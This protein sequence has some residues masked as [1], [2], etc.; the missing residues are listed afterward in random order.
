MPTRSAR[1]RVGMTTETTRSW[2][3]TASSIH[4]VT[5]GISRT[6]PAWVIRA[7]R[8]ATCHRAAINGADALSDHV[9]R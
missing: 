4:C 3:P 2:G 6:A 8:W 1:L 5:A 7:H 9:G